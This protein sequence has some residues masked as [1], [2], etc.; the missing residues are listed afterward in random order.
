MQGIVLAEW[1]VPKPKDW[2]SFVNEIEPDAALEF[3]RRR[4]RRGTALSDCPEHDR[5]PAIVPARRI[6]ILEEG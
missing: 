1:P 5:F 6:A 2:L 4:T 3:V